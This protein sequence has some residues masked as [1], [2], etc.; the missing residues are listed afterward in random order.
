MQCQSC[1]N[2]KEEG[3][4]WD[5]PIA[6]K[7]NVKS[8]LTTA[9]QPLRIFPANAVLSHHAWLVM[10]AALQRKDA[11]CITVEMQRTHKPAVV[12]VGVV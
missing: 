12:Q 7:Y 4:G 1:S 6:A 3:G 2:S 8:R 11:R 9:G 5:T 10:G